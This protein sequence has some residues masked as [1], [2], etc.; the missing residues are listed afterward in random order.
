MYDLQHQAYLSVSSTPRVA[1]RYIAKNV[2]LWTDLVP[3]LVIRHS[4]S[5]NTSQQGHAR[6]CSEQMNSESSDG[7][8]ISVDRLVL[9]SFYLIVVVAEQMI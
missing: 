7:S 6:T 3:T 2:T 1:A 4:G 5:G 8:E 9:I